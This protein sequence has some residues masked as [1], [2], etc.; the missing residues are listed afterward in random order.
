MTLLTRISNEQGLSIASASVGGI[1]MNGIHDER[2]LYTPHSGTD[3]FSVTLITK[4]QI[5]LA[6]EEVAP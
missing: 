6:V 3:K 4:I 1:G 5:V 2:D